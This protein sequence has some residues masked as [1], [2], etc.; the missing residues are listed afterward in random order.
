V[1]LGKVLSSD[2][3]DMVLENDGSEYA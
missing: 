1:S 3:D 2:K